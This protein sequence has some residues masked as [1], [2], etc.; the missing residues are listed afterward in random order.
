VHLRQKLCQL[1]ISSFCYA[2]QALGLLTFTF[3]TPAVQRALRII[4]VLCS[5]LWYSF[6]RAKTFDQATI[7]FILISKAASSTNAQLLK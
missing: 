7:L 3:M 4:V 1:L 6:L 2:A 5:S